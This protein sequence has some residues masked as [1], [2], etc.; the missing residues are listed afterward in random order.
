MNVVTYKKIKA[1]VKKEKRGEGEAEV[2]CSFAS[3]II[4]F[5]LITNHKKLLQRRNYE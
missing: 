2:G 4:P 1:K 5:N 3:C